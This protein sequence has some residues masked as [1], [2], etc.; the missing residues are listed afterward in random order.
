[1]I[2]PTH[3]VELFSLLGGGRPGDFTS[4][5]NAQLAVLPATSHVSIL[6][7]TDLLVPIITSFLNT[8][9]SETR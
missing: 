9:V 1:M 4:L 7:H 3:A 5:P 8:S 6:S 2:H